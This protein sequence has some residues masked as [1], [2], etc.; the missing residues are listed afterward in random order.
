M[1]WQ[2]NLIYAAVIAIAVAVLLVV[3]YIKKGQYEEEARGCILAEIKRETGWPLLKVVKPTPD[4]WVRVAK[5]DYR[6]PIAKRKEAKEG[7][8]NN[9]DGQRLLPVILEWAFYP[10]NPFLG[11][12][13]LRTPIRKQAW[14]ENDPEPIVREEHRTEVTAADAQAHT[15]EMDAMN[16]AIRIQEAEARQ[17]QLQAALANQPNKMIVYVMLGIAILLSLIGIVPN[18]PFGG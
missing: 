6:L 15:R 4:G 9:P 18:L 3:A 10:A 16:I 7:E 13:V 1:G 8:K 5:G 11:L 14:W 12:K 17:K 2:T